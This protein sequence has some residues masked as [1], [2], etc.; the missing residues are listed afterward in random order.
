[1]DDGDTPE[2]WHAVKKATVPAGISLYEQCPPVQIEGSNILNVFSEPKAMAP[3]PIGNGDSP[4]P[5]ERPI[6]PAIGGDAAGLA[7]NSIRE[8]DT[9]LGSDLVSMLTDVAHRASRLGYVRFN[10]YKHIELQL[11]FAIFLRRLGPSKLHVSSSRP[12]PRTRTTLI[13][14][15]DRNEHAW[16]FA[17]I[18][19]DS[20]RT[21]SGDCCYLDRMSNAWILKSG[22]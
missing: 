22:L 19:R 5:L 16:V 2:K 1:M 7:P 21:A 12:G 4:M 17:R 18:F 14:S 20:L 11:L 3:K 9:P 13:T 6:V 8:G 10:Y 15:S